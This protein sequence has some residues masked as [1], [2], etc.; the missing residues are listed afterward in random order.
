M[1]ALCTACSSGRLAD[2]VL[3]AGGSEQHTTRL[4]GAM[5]TAL[6]TAAAACGRAAEVLADMPP[7]RRCSGP[8]LRWRPLPAAE[9]EARRQ[10]L[11]ELCTELMTTYSEKIAQG[12]LD[13]ALSI[14]PQRVSRPFAGL[15]KVGLHVCC[16]PAETP[17]RT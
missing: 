3:T 10:G 14:R 1:T 17:G 15:G 11:F 12:G 9:W 8:S 6:S 7:L 2:L 16:G 4:H 5:A 13:Y